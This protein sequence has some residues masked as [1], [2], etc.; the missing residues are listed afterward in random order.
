MAKRLITQYAPTFFTITDDTID[1]SHVNLII[2]LLK[3]C[4][5][6][7][8]TIHIEN[9]NDTDPGVIIQVKSESDDTDE[10][11]FI[12]KFWLKFLMSQE[13]TDI[14]MTWSV[15]NNY[16]PEAVGED[17]W[18]TLGRMHKHAA[19]VTNTS[20]SDYGYYGVARYEAV[21]TEKEDII[22]YCRYADEI[23]T[24]GAVSRKNEVCQPIFAITRF[25]KIIDDELQSAIG[26][27]YFN[28]QNTINP[29]GSGGTL[30]YN[31]ISPKSAANDTSSAVPP[32]GGSGL[33]FPD[34]DLT[35][36]KNNYFFC[37]NNYGAFWSAGGANKSAVN[38]NV[39]R[40]IYTNT[41]TEQPCLT[42][43]GLLYTHDAPYIATTTRMIELSR[44]NYTDGLYLFSGHKYYVTYGLAFLDE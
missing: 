31:R 14:I 3:K 38:W 6:Q 22:V 34:S 4:N 9:T 16:N 28:G 44:T 26:I 18:Y 1:Q 37:G 32:Y 29:I 25:S 13:S 24:S 17:T 15:S 21:I 8:T 10:S 35:S 41:P 11:E 12:D 36:L 33:I 30:Y 23:I 42:I 5:D 27:I 39:K 2:D 40:P 7:L 19:K 43:L 20:S